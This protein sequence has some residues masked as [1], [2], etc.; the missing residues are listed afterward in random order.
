MTWIL[1]INAN[2][3]HLAGFAHVIDAKT[4]VCIED[5]AHSLAML[6]RFTGHTLRPYSVAEHSLHVADLAQRA[7]ASATLQLAALL[8]DAHEAYTNDLS[9]PAKI[10]VDVDVS[11]QRLGAGHHYRAWSDF[12]DRVAARVRRHFGLGTA[13]FTARAAIREWDLIALATERRDLTRYTPAQ[14]QPWAIL[15]DGTPHA[16]E[17]DLDRFIDH[18][19]DVSWRWLKEQFLVRYEVLKNASV[20]ECERLGEVA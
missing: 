2:E 14:H 12:E 9:S 3:H 8:H 13:Y 6:P 19:T 17:P 4:P 7:G 10:A 15:G 11:G 1:T 18:R 20:R 5:I 16:I